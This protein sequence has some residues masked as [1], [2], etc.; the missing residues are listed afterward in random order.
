MD[1]DKFLE[2]DIIEFLDEQAML[3]AEKAAGLRE[4]EF[5]MYEITQD[6]SKEINEALKERDLRKAQK[7][8]EDVKNRY[9]KA[10]E[11]SLNKKRLY[12]IM[13][14]I[15]ERIKDYEAKEEGKKSFFETIKEYEEKGLFTRPELFQKKE[16]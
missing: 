12:I 5:D 13:E 16:Y 6:Y 10:P 1:F 4:E 15:Y 11:N 14:E 2:K 7:V 3:V 8:F 9:L